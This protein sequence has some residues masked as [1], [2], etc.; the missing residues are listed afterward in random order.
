MLQ[1]VLADFR[2]WGRVHILT[3]LDYRL[4]GIS[5]TADRIIR[6]RH[7][8]YF[9]TIDDIL[10]KSDAALII[11]PESDAILS[12]LTALAEYAGVPLLG[13]SSDGATIA[14]NKWECSRRFTEN[15][16][17]TPDTWRSNF[18]QAAMDAKKYGF[19]LVIKPIDGAGCEAVSLASDISSFKLAFEQTNLVHKDFL[20]QRYIAGMHAS[21]SILVSANRVSSLSL[22]RQ[23]IKIGNAFVYQGALVPLQHPQRRRALELARRAVSLV[24]GLRGYVGVDMILT[25]E[26]CYLI[27]INPRITSS[28]IALR[29]VINI[30]LAEAIW[31]SCRENFLPKN[32][33]ISGK[34]SF[35]KEEL[36]VI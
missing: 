15:G 18:A 3:T 12:R 4:S 23:L 10:A 32:T 13:A 36:S 14:A 20:L 26:E 19:P 31:R 1:A 7:E 34:A 28:Y 11:A 22:N 21:V 6:L 30:N 24:P 29:Q 25:D 5:L 2:S 33:F 9:G 35:C 27:E 16:L 17:P 8:E